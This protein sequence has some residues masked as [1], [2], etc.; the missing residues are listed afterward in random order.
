[1]AALRDVHEGLDPQAVKVA[2]RHALTVNAM[3]DHYMAD[4]PAMKPNPRP[5]NWDTNRPRLIAT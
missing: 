1:M 2:D 3:I 4:G 5:S